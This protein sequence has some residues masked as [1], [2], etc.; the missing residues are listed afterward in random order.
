MKGNTKDFSFNFFLEKA[1]DGNQA[2]Q[3]CRCSRPK[4]YR[5]TLP[6]NDADRQFCQ[7]GNLSLP[8]FVKK[9][10]SLPSPPI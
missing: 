9:G 4:K 6:Q 7:G 10:R 8:P 3:G 5:G 1:R 2:T